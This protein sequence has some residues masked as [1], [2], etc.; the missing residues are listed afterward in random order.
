MNKIIKFQYQHF[1][2]ILCIV[3]EKQSKESENYCR[4]VESRIRLELVFSIEEDQN[5]IKYAHA[6]GRERC[7]TNEIKEKFR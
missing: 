4:F 1:L 3:N 6:T 2:L 7:L 5:Q